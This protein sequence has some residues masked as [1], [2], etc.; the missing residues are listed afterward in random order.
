VHAHLSA[1][2]IGKSVSLR[3]VRGGVVQDAAIVVGERPHGGD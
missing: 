3:F 1:A 2:A